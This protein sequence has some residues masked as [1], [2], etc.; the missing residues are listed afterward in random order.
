VLTHYQV[1]TFDGDKHPDLAKQNFVEG[2]TH[3]IGT[4]LKDFVEQDTEE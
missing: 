4:A 1:E 3:F 2:W